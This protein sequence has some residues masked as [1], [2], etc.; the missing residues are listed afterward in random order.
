MASQPLMKKAMSSL[1]SLD[2]TN[3]AD[4]IARFLINRGKEELNTLFFNR[5][6]KFLDENEECSTLLPVTTEFFKNIESHQFAEFIETL[7]EAF[8]TDLTNLI[9]NLNNLID[10]PKYQRL[11]ADLPEIRLAIRSVK[12]VSALSQAEG[13]LL[14]DSV[15]S[16]LSQL[17]EWHEIHPN[18]GNSWKLLNVISQSIRFM[19]DSTIDSFVSQ[20][21]NTRCWIKI[22]DITSLMTNQMRLRIFLGL[23][24]EKSD[25]IRFIKGQNSIDVQTFLRNNS[26]RILF[27]GGLIENF[28]LIASDVDKAIQDFKEKRIT[29]SLTDNDYYTYINKAINATEYGFKV[30]NIIQP[31]INADPYILM[32]R[33][34][35][36]LYRNV[37]TK[38]YSNAVMNTYNILKMVFA[39]VQVLIDK[40]KS[41]ALAGSASTSLNLS[42]DSLMK[43]KTIQSFLKY[44][45]FIASVV[46]AES[47]EEVGNIIEAAALPAGS[48]SI[49]QK[50][51]FN[52]SFNGYIGYGLD[53][54]GGLYARGIY[55]PLGFA[56]S[57]GLSKKKGG[58]ISLFAGIIDV[59]GVASYRLENG[60]TDSLRQQVRLESIFSPSVQLIYGINKTP[61]SV[62]AGWRRTP[63][64][65]FSKQDGFTTIR[66]TDAFN[67]AVL[68]DIPLFNILNR[69]FEN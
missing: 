26:I 46:K 62:C 41:E 51:R 33:N 63:K 11:L 15:I 37:F 13:G 19:P 27:L 18:L 22:S 21:D 43:P 34:A 17:N 5:L 16:Q 30:A 14:P 2:V 66:S 35:N 54:N 9:V 23:I 47:S 52:I 6:K 7:R 57:T 50:S 64:L 10:L 67:V 39:E 32:A 49:K 42:S 25:G 58:A 12:I 28:A 65:I 59:G 24:Y 36:E 61:I 60:M 38:N 29:N 55:A 45:N 48:Y 56:F 3:I 53:F 20:D 31:G 69:P 68:I 8:H 40:K 44:G 4:G 1:G